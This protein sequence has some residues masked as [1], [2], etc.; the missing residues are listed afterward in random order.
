M[1]TKRASRSPRTHAPAHQRDQQEESAFAA[2]LSG[3]VARVPGARAAALVDRGGETVDYAGRGDPFDMRVAAAH[4]R[5]VLDDARAQGSLADARS[6]VIRAAS[7]SYVLRSLPDGYALVLCLSR[8]AGFRGLTRAIPAFTQQLA[9]EAGW[10][11]R[12]APW[13]A[14]EVL[15]DDRGSPHAIRTIKLDEPV[16]VLGRFRALVPEHG[17]AWRVRLR[18]GIELTLVRE[19]GGFWYSDELIGP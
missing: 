2:I 15:P 19:S 13:H 3:L 16:E 10:V 8:G 18:S 9:R 4:F 5:L 17:R 12:P 1:N 14:V 11:E 6:F 7:A